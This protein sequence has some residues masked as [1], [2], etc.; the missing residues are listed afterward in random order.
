MRCVSVLHHTWPNITGRFSTDAL[1]I[2]AQ[3]LMLP[4]IVVKW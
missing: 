2:L 4:E 3:R 1:S